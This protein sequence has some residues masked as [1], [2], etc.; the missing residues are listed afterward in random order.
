MRWKRLTKSLF[1]LFRVPGTLRARLLWASIVLLPILIVF[2]GGALQRAFETSLLTSVE[3]QARLQAF[4]LLGSAEFIEQEL[5]LPR[6]LQ[7]PR[8]SQVQSGLSALVFNANGELKWRSESSAL[9]ADELIAR[10]STIEP[11][12]GS[13]R[14]SHLKSEQF[15]L[16]LYPLIWEIDGSEYRYMISILNAD[17]DAM[18]ELTTFQTQLWG[19]LSA[20]YLLALLLQYLILRWGLKPLKYLADD[21]S[22]IESG[23]AID[24][25]GQYPGEVEPLT[26][27]LN[28]L[29]DSER[30]QR[31]RY[32]N[33]LADLAHS[34]KTPLAV[35][36]GAASE[37]HTLE[38]YQRLIDEQSDRM[39]QIVQYQ[40]S[41]AVKSKERPLGSA[42]PVALAVERICGALSKV[43]SE[44]RMQVELVALDAKQFA[45]DERDLMEL[46]GNLLE[47]AFK[48]GQSQVRVDAELFEQDLIL[49]I[50]DDGPGVGTGQQHT[51]L[52]RGA[53]LDTSTPGQGIGLAVCADIISSYN[54]ALE[55]RRSTLGGAEFRIQ[56]PAAISTLSPITASPLDE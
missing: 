24:L 22:R 3:S 30:H 42:V 40:L 44:K 33:T 31:E 25:R 21:I 6:T 14:F 7:E 17:F 23:D 34:L 11:E 49:C 48:Y 39:T 32:R 26:R 43:Y 35:I 8:F 20:V 46:L 56:L 38:S 12:P 16:Y 2:A 47:N 10:I 52:E 50:S 37:D 15:F 28:R 45:G 13:S 27:N 9:V 5:V 4:A 51:I 36:K 18:E 55:V 54:G 1:K 29:I 53:R 41:R 19:W